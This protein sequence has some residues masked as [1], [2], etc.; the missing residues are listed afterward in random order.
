MAEQKQTTSRLREGPPRR[1][2]VLSF[3]GGEVSINLSGFG[4]KN[5]C[6]RFIFD[7]KA[8]EWQP[9]DERE[10]CYLEVKLARSE[11]VEIRDW[12]TRQLEAVVDEQ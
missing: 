11:M 3:E 2:A 12:I 4:A 9:H 8:V 5:G 10:G 1:S 7:E 6:G